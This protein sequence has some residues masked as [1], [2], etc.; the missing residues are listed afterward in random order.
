[1]AGCNFQLLGS[2][3]IALDDEAIMEI[4]GKKA[5]LLLAYLILAFHMPQSRRHIAFDF[6]PDSTE[7]QALS[8]LRKL[9]HDLRVMHATNRPVSQNYS[10]IYAMET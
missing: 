2:L 10:H 4:P 1:L 8:N 9:I 3:R 5:G 6:W 7:K